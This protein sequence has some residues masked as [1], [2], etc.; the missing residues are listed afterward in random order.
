[1]LIAATALEQGLT[2]V[3]HSTQRFAIVTGLTVLDWAVP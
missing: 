2:L 1:L 3:T